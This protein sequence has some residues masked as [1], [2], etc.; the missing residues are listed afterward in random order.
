MAVG[1]GEENGNKYYLL[2]NYWGADWG[3]KGYIKIARDVS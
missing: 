3:E 1:Y 2:K